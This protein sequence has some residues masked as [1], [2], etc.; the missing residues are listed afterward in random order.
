MRKQ[1]W[2]K[3]DPIKNYFPLPNEIYSLGLS[4]TAIAVYGYLLCR[5]DRKTYECLAS[6]RMISE[7]IGKSVTTVR[8][9]VCELEER[10]LITTERT[11]VITR[12]GRKQNG[13]LRYH[14]LPIRSAIEQFNERQFRAAELEWARQ[15]MQ[16]KLSRQCATQEPLSVAE[17]TATPHTP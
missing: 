16:A 4:A 7:A 2:P 15:K 12:D 3:R 10:G 9:Y 13:R 8:K 5:E 1:H 6:Y 14:I 11:S 17:R